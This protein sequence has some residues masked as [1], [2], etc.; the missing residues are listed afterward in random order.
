MREQRPCYAVQVQFIVIGLDLGGRPN[1]EVHKTL[2]ILGAVELSAGV[3]IVGTDRT[4]ASIGETLAAHLAPGQKLKVLATAHGGW[5]DVLEGAVLV[6]R[7]RKS[8]GDSA[9]P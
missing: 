2:S 6:P 7:R 9:K 3:W 5:A 8:D 4:A 1:R